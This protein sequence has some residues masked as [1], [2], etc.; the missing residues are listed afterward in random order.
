MQK[1]QQPSELDQGDAIFRN[2]GLRVQPLLTK[3]ELEVGTRL[4]LY[5]N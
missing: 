5:G 2:I 4:L 3:K 1:T